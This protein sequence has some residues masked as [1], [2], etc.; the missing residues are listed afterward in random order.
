MSSIELARA[1]AIT[2]LSNLFCQ[3]SEINSVIKSPSS[4]QFKMSTTTTAQPDDAQTRKLISTLSLGALIVC[5]IVIA[6]PPRKFDVYTLTLLSLT[7]VGANQVC[8][9]YTG[10]SILERQ[11]RWNER[12]ANDSLPEKAREMQK[13]LREERAAKMGVTVEEAAK[14]KADERGILKKIWMGNAPDD[15]K[16]QRDKREKVALEEGK[17]YGDM[18][19]DQIWEVWNWGRDKAEEVKENDEK[20]VEERRKSN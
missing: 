5:P 20:V 3:S 15:W 10:S 7:A 18:I 14:E 9:D 6:L 17:G 13:R 16:E 12:W 19:V 8:A 1:D 11:R 2:K 4:S